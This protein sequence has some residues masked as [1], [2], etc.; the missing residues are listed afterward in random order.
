MLTDASIQRL[1]VTGKRRHVADTGGLYIIVNASGKKTWVSRYTAPDGKRRWQYHGDYPTTP[2]KIA[3]EKNREVQDMADG[4]IDPQNLGEGLGIDPTLED[5]YK[6]FIKKGVDRKGNPL[7]ESTLNGYIQAFDKDI[8]PIIGK[9]K[10]RGLRKRDIIPTLEKIVERGSEN[11]A[12]QVYRRLQRVM[13]FA[14]ARDIIEFNPMAA[15]EPIGETNRRDRVLSD[16]EL[17]LFLNWRPRSDQAYR[18]LQLILITG[19][20]PGEVAGMTKDEIDGDWWTIPKERS[21]TKTPHRVYLTDLAK[22]LLP[23]DHFTI[24][25]QVAGRTISRALISEADIP[26]KR[27]VGG[28]P[29]PLHIDKFVPHDLRRTMATG[30][31]SLGF[32]DEVINAVQGRVKLGIIGT[33]NHYR[34]DSE[35]EKAAKAWTTKIKKIMG[36]N[37]AAKVIKLGVT[38]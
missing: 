21:K 1:K 11:Q 34:Y 22:K 31:A 18:I 32:S 28:Q 15:M 29:S 10:I 23:D 33:Y 35:R 9:C 19:A 30:L 8:L 14:A 16:E 24:S 25:R 4:G 26:D 13:S 7:R 20:R 12:N 5:V 17:K 3:R 27:K 36:I 38:G 37:T 6:L 2:L